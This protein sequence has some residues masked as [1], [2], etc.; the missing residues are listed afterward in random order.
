MSLP[1]NADPL[2]ASIAAGFPLR[3]IPAPSVR[4][5]AGLRLG[6]ADANVGE[7]WLAGPDSLV[8]ATRGEQ[9]SLDALAAAAGVALVGEAGMRLLGPRFPLIVKLIDAAEWLSLQVHPSDELASQLYGAGALGKTEAW[10][11]LDAEL[12]V[13]LITGPGRTLAEDELREAIADGTLDMDGCEVRPAVPG[14]TL[15]VEAG[16]LHA[17]GAG[18]FVYE[19]EQ[20]S[21]LTFRV[22]DWG[23]AAVPGRSL[24]RA[25]SL[26]ALRAD[27]HA[28]PVGRDWQL[29]GGAL[30]VRE[31]R[32][33]I[34]DLPGPIDRRPGGRS[35]EVVTVIEGEAQ[36]S[37]GGWSER[38][39]RWETLIVPASAAAYRIEGIAAGRVCIGSV[40]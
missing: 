10:L 9:V 16:T 8:E 12:G 39:A 18:A 7:M 5:W 13:D 1:T 27:A 31:F 38:L 11:V 23:R 2:I 15:L 25:E 29:D 36:A 40:P 6:D 14:N 26:R 32:L 34:L 21:D 33:E 28:I 17:I 30:E 4:P 3:P 37:G 19:I 20:P 22:S 35:L 24:H